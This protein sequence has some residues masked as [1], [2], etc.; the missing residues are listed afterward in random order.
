MLSSGGIRHF[1]TVS[2]FFLFFFSLPS[3]PEKR[4]VVVNVVNIILYD[5]VNECELIGT[6]EKE[7]HYI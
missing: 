2:L 3:S 6:E 4:R 7:L 1:L 5:E